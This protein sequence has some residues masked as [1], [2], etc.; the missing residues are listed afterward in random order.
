MTIAAGVMCPDGIILAADSQ[1]TVGE[2]L[3]VFKPKLVELPLLSAELKAVVVAAGDGTFIDVLVERI[4]EQLDLVNPYV[5]SAKQAIQDAIGRACDEI[6]PHYTTQADKPKARLIIGVRATDGLMMLDA[7]VPMVKT[8][9]PYAFIGWGGDLATYKAKQLALAGMPTTV[10]APL[11]AY[12]LDVVKKNVE[13]CGGDTYLAVITSDGTVEHKSQ[14]FISHAA[15]GYENTAWALEALVFPIIATAIMP[16]GR[17]CLTAIAEL[18]KPDAEIEKQVA[19]GIVKVLEARKQGV[20]IGIPSPEQQVI[21]ANHLWSVGLN[22]IQKAEIDLHGV[23]MVP[24]ELHKQIQQ[25]FLVSGEAGKAASAAL[26][27]G[28]SV[29][30][31]ELLSESVRI[32]DNSE[33]SSPLIVQTLKGQP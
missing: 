2:S 32:L 29:K 19:E 23:G 26:T 31:K 8:A 22:L 6:W 27:A 5:A 21:N 7:F 11:T 18:E 13:F 14:D 30:A 25:R 9:D 12:I 3:K 4:S 10:A 33:L 15:Q 20:Q 17:D 16:D 1:E 24:D 28:D